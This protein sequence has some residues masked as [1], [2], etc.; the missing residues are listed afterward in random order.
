MCEKDPI[1]VPDSFA[2]TKMMVNLVR[3]LGGC[4]VGFG[5]YKRGIIATDSVAGVLQYPGTR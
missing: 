2:V 4:L 5:V 3:I 1:I